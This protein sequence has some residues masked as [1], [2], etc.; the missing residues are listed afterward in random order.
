MAIP[1]PSFNDRWGIRD[2]II[3]HGVDP[4]VKKLAE[5]YRAIVVNYYDPL[6]DKED[7][8]PDKIHPNAEGA[9]LMGDILYRV[10]DETIMK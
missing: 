8:F 5:E 7:V 4:V 10:M 1:P 9:E 3:V 2:S 6:L